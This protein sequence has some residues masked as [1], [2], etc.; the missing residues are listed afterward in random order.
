MPI[1]SVQLALPKLTCN[2]AEQRSVLPAQPCGYHP[3]LGLGWFY[4]GAFEHCWSFS[5]IAASHGVAMG[6][7]GKFFP[8]ASCLVLVHVSFF[9]KGNSRLD[10]REDCRSKELSDNNQTVIVFHRFSKIHQSRSF[11][12]HQWVVLG[13][14]RDIR[15]STRS[16]SVVIIFDKT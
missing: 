1:F 5:E 4:W 7:L 16:T 10:K 13:I 6:K 15:K 2:T 8:H 3:A 11:P 12:T 14:P 9:G